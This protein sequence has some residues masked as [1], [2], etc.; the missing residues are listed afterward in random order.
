[1]EQGG[2]V[3]RLPGVGQL[4]QLPTCRIFFLFLVW[5]SELARRREERRG[6]AEP[7]PGVIT[8]WYV[9]VV[10]IGMWHYTPRLR[11]EPPRTSQSFREAMY[12]DYIV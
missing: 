5:I 3:E 6:A 1:M 11:G 8:D 4:Q 10:G 12:I 7:Y 9:L 2:H